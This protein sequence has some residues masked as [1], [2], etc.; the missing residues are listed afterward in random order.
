MIIV[1]NKWIPFNGF[2][3]VTIWPFIFT[4]KDLDY[5]NLHH[6]LINHE[7]THG[8]QQL[9]LLLIFFYIIYIIE[10]IFKGYKNIS[11]EK[12]A[13]S[14]QNNP[15]YLKTRKLFAMWRK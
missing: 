14:N 7:Y 2:T 13:Y 12:E 10:W 15:D 11:F 4:K 3:A 8:R 6:E 1:H 9:E 5:I